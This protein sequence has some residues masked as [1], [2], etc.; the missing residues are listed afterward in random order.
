MVSASREEGR[1]LFFRVGDKIRILDTIVSSWSD[2]QNFGALVLKELEV[3]VGEPGV[4][5]EITRGG[6][7]I[8]LKNREGLL[9][10]YGIEIEKEG[11]ANG[12]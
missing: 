8:E 2:G 1:C 9:P 12:K 11:I 6:F 10:V 3:L 5:A 4:I 7:L